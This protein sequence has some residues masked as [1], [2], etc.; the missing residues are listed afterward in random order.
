METMG[1]NE[2][3]R[4]LQVWQDKAGDWRWRVVAL[5]GNLPDA[6]V[7]ESGEGYSTKADAREAALRE[8]PTFAPTP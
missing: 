7:S 5:R 1:H 4:Q 2:G 6:I 3:G 8:N